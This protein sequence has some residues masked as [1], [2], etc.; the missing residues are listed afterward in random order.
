MQYKFPFCQNRLKYFN[1]CP[2]TCAP[3]MHM[4][5]KYIFWKDMKSGSRYV[6]SVKACETSACISNSPHPV[7]CINPLFLAVSFHFSGL[8]QMPVH[9]L[10]WEGALRWYCSNRGIRGEESWS[11]GLQWGLMDWGSANAVRPLVRTSIFTANESPALIL[12]RLRLWHQ[13]RWLIRESK[14]HCR[15]HGRPAWSVKWSVCHHWLSEAWSFTV[16]LN[17]RGEAA[18]TQGFTSKTMQK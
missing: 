5:F 3:D 11:L 7:L 14:H 16:I 8:F 18:E 17:E 2:S 13:K 15:S 9:S 6:W 4:Y 12:H 10:N 1:I